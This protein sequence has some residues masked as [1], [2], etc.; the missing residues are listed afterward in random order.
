[1]RQKRIP[2]YP[3]PDTVKPHQLKPT[4]QNASAYAANRFPKRLAQDGPQKFCALS[5]Q[6]PDWPGHLQ[7]GPCQIVLPKPHFE[8]GAVVLAGPDQ[9]SQGAQIQ[10]DQ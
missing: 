9:N 2:A 7:F 3:F 5:L 4:P 1:M 8:E 10:N 6:H